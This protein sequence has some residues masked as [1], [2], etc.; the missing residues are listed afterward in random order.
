MGRL[1]WRVLLYIFIFV[2]EVFPVDDL[3]ILGL[4]C[5]GVAFAYQVVVIVKDIVVFVSGV[6]QHI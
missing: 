5:L 4:L 3:Y 1:L 6:R 2:E